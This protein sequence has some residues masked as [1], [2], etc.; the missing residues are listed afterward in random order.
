MQN[1]ID[2]IIHVTEHVTQ[3]V[4]DVLCS[5]EMWYSRDFH[6]CVLHLLWLSVLNWPLYRCHATNG[7]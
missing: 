5:K 2:M 1:A 6:L 4:T 3:H 7:L